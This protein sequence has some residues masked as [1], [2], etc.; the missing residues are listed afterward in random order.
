M[1][2]RWKAL[3]ATMTAALVLAAGVSLLPVQATHLPADKIGVAASTL[4]VMSAEFSPLGGLDE[5]PPLSLAGLLAEAGPD[6]TSET[7]TLFGSTM[8]TSSPTDLLIRV[9]AECALWTDVV[10]EGNADSEAIATVKVWAELDG[11]PVLVASDDPDEGKVVFCNRA[12]RMQTLEQENENFT[13]K[14][15][16]ATRNAESFQWI[17]LNVGSGVHALEVFAQL[18]TQVTGTG[19][20]KAAVGKRVLAVEPVKLAND[21]SI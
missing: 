17:A 8:R 9:T 18:E 12:F 19:E 3:A 16:L 21:I 15:Y 1:Q 20:A 14:T 2:T 4:E 13:I 5:K 7:R 6:T 10:V 11:N